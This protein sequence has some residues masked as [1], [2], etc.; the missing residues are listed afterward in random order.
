VQTY[1]LPWRTFGPRVVAREVVTVLILLGSY[2]LAFQQRFEFR[3][4]DLYMRVMIESMVLVVGALYIGMLAN[5]THLRSWRH[6]SMRDVLA[7]VR[8]LFAAM[9]VLLLLR[10][11][12]VDGIVMLDAWDRVPLSV[13]VAT[14]G[15]APTFEVGVRALWRLLMEDRERRLTGRP[16]RS[17]ALLVG[18]GVVAAGV[19]RDS[20]VNGAASLA[21]VGVITDDTGLHG[22]LVQGVAVL[23]D[24]AGLAGHAA[25]TGANTIVIALDEPDPDRIRAIARAAAPL[26]LEVRIR[27]GSVLLDDAPAT[28]DVMVRPLALEDLLQRPTARLDIAGLT[29]VL[30]GQALLVTGAGG[31]IGSELVRQLV[32]FDP[33]H[34]VLVDRAETP[35]WAIEREVRALA[36]DLRVTAVICD[37][38]DRGLIEQVLDRARPNAVFHA[39]ALK[40]V[41]IL[42]SNVG[43]A[44]VTNVVGTR[45]LVDAC[46]AAGVP[47]FV[48]VSSDKAVDP[49][50]VMGATKRVAECY[51]Q[52]VAD[53]T[54]R[55]YVSVR[56]GNVLGSA[57]SVVPVFEEQIAAGGPI[58]ITDPD[59][60][61]YFMTI[62]EACQLI[63]QA[64]L[65]G[66][67]GEV[68]VLDMGEPVRIV[69]LAH[70]LIRL[71]GLTPEVDIAIEIVGARPGEKLH[72]AL[73]MADEQ[74][75]RS[76]HP[77]ILVA[78]PRGTKT[79]DAVSAERIDQLH[80]LVAAGAY[81]DAR[82]TLFE[83][84]APTGASPA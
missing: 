37:V 64:A 21:V 32:R 77:S 44:I 6:T 43:A 74:V 83:L 17:R 56:F 29:D 7:I 23:G 71:K 76:L 28:D 81:D 63:V 41:P 52:A 61:R 20:R 50:S 14:M 3:I 24:E 84:T 22:Q 8:G 62:P 68:L 1:R 70:D 2:K 75:D 45:T 69:D 79:L 78:R 80:A 19:L 58:T 72:E 55:A 67:G 15:I 9:I 36:P 53:A 25:L 27:P 82:A 16:P 4:P 48:N 10:A 13:I 59:M 35:L 49:T 34:L 42:E 40:H 26:G 38:G 5:R 18:S 66:S 31:S 33:S 30:T 60:T 51:V 54:G 73:T 39:A 47:R 46:I 65:I 57:G 11:L 12:T